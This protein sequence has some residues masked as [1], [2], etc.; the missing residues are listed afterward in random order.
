MKFGR[1]RHKKRKTKISIEIIIGMV[2]LVVA[3]LLDLYPI[4]NFKI[5][6]VLVIVISYTILSLIFNKSEFLERFKWFK[7]GFLRK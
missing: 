2:S 1:Y 5:D 3:F 7:K 4:L 6:G